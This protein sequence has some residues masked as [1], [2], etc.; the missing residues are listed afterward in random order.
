MRLAFKQ[1]MPPATLFV[2][3]FA[4]HVTNKFTSLLTVIKAHFNMSQSCLERQKKIMKITNKH[5]QLLNIYEH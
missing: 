5:R 3:I 4:V 1:T 2:H